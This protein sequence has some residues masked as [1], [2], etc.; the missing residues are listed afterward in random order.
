MQYESYWPRHI[1]IMYR[2]SVSYIVQALKPVIHIKILCLFIISQPIASA[3][4]TYTT[5]FTTTTTTT[6]K[7]STCHK[8]L[9]LLCYFYYNPFD[10]ELKKKKNQVIC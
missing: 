7:A 4:T 1:A 5:T 9:Q 3:P 2:P 8:L 10:H 6:P